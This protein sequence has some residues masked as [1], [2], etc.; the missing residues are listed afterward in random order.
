M[1]PNALTDL[2]M[3]AQRALVSASLGDGHELAR[4]VL[5]FVEASRAAGSPYRHEAPVSGERASGHGPRNEDVELSLA[6]A[7]E[8]ELATCQDRVA[9]LT[10]E[11]EDLRKLAAR[12]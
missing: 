5:R 8:R 4:A 6:A 10:R 2:E 1:D 3:L 12:R 7:L 9:A 11:N